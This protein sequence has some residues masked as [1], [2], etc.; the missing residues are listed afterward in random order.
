MDLASVGP[1]LFIEFWN[2]AQKIPDLWST[3]FDPG[4]PV[5]TPRGLKASDPRVATAVRTALAEA[6]VALCDHNAG[7]FAPLYS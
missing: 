4:D 3:P 2:D 6:V 1:Q 5:N 7:Q